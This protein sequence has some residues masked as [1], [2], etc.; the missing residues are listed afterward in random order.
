MLSLFRL[1]RVKCAEGHVIRTRLACLHRKMT[2]I[3]TGDA[4]LG[5]GTK[6]YARLTRVAIPLPQ[7]HTI[8]AESLGKRHAVVDDER[9]FV[10]GAQLLQRLGSAGDRVLVQPL[11]AELKRGNR[12]AIERSLERILKSRVDYGRRD[13]IE[14]ARWAAH[15]ALEPVG[16]MGV[17]L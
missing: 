3:V 8:R 10:I 14:L 11:E 2:A 4:D 16:K 17:E 12:P 15:V 9:A 13:E 6:Q 1:C 5:R 7:M